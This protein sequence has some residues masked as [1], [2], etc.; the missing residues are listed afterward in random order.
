MT[1]NNQNTELEAQR[2]SGNAKDRFQ[3]L[4]LKTVEKSQSEID[5]NN[6]LKNSTAQDIG[7]AQPRISDQQKDHL[8]STHSDQD[9]PTGNQN[10]KRVNVTQDGVNYHDKKIINQLLPKYFSLNFYTQDASTNELM[11]QGVSQTYGNSM[12]MFEENA[13]QSEQTDSPLLNTELDDK[14]TASESHL[15]LRN[16]NIEDKSQQ[17][18]N[19]HKQSANTSE[20]FD[21]QFIRTNTFSIS[22]IKN[23]E[24]EAMSNHASS[25]AFTSTIENRFGTQ[26]WFD[27]FNQSIV[28]MSRGAGHSAILTLNPPNLGPIKVHVKML[29]QVAH[30]MFESSNPEVRLALESGLPKLRE[31]LFSCGLELGEVCIKERSQNDQSEIKSGL[32][33][34]RILNTFV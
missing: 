16:K 13:D 7:S 17:N 33:S 21:S 28:W 34:S 29:N 9:R 2:I 3:L 31:M 24:Y 6:R 10:Q 20:I 1:V 27:E 19:E 4:F 22:G 11:K 15:T 8:N 5:R 32:Y 14:R 25:S 23:T 26:S 30:T 12:D 18:Q